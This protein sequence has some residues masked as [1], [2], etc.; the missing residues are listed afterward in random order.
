[1]T[2]PT[3]GQTE[4]LTHA[5]ERFTRRFKV[6]EATAAMDN[7]LSALDV[8]TL[9]FVSDHKGCGLGDVARYLQVPLTTMSSAVDR[10][11]RKDMVLRE[12]PQENRRAVALSLTEEGEGAVAGYIAGYGATCHAM[13]EALDPTERDEF[14]RLTQKISKSEY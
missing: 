11:V 10:L 12:R 13:L 4:Q 1:M 5:L 8:Q 3:P 9:L 6:A 7:A 2:K 14:V